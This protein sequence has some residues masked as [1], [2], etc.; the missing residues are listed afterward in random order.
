MKAFSG[1]APEKP[2]SRKQLPV[3]GY[4]AKILDAEE[5]TYDWGSVLLISFDIAEG[6]YMNFF[7]K[8]YDAQQSEDKKWR[9][10]YR[11]NIPKDDGSEK[12]G[13]ATRNTL[14]WARTM[15][16]SATGTMPSAVTLISL[17]LPWPFR[18]RTMPVCW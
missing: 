9:G 12:D 10:T 17:S 15:P 13:W 4:I 8:D 1:F 5:V 7:E 3:G 18:I 16:I 6:D 11:L 2:S 14:P